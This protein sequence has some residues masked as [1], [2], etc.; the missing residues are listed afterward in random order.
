MI[1]KIQVLFISRVCPKFC[2]LGKFTI[3]P[4][5][6]LNISL[7]EI[8]RFIR[9]KHPNL[10]FHDIDLLD[11]VKKSFLLLEI[12]SVNSLSTSV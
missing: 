10:Q 2:S 7:R 3:G 11:Q 6:I 5:S 12:T 9:V 8:Y 1:L 4:K